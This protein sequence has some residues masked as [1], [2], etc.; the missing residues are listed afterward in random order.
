[1]INKLRKAI[2]DENELDSE[3][4]R[5]LSLAFL[6]ISGAL[7]FFNYTQIRTF[8][9]DTELT[10]S[11]SFLSTIIAICL[12]TP[13]YLRGILKWN[14]SIYSL[15]SLTLILLVFGSFTE[16]ALGGKD[17][18]T[19]LYLL[20]A[21]VLLSWL[22]IKVI[23]GISWALAL[24][25]AIYSAIDNNMAMGFYGFIYIASGFIGLVLHSG[26]APGELFNG[27]KGEYSKTASSTLDTAKSDITASVEKIT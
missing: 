10:F 14:K 5:L 3:T 25:A 15:L 22:G 12:I 26:L 6:L 24:A 9:P 23:A 11:P 4:L 2:A 16:L 18:N 19:I 1:V 21:A 27:I 8:W 17:N 13:L 20:V 7:S